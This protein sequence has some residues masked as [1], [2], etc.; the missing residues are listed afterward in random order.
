MRRINLTHTLRL[1]LVLLIAVV[2]CSDD[3]APPPSGPTKSDLI[4]TTG[5]V[6]FIY[7]NVAADG[8]VTIDLELEDGTTERLMFAPFYWGEDSE[9]R[10]DVYAKI[11]ELEI[12]DCVT[13]VGRRTD[14][15]IEIEDI[16][17]L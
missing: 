14:R 11:K 6:T 2:G 5:D 1:L 17:K 3:G 10:W 16:T 15:G 7:D 9:E 13:A 4:E 8:G 12:G